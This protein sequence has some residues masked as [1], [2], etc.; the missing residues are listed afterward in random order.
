M[1]RRAFNPKG[2]ELHR[3]L[4]CKNTRGATLCR[5]ACLAFLL[6]VGLQSGSQHP[7]ALL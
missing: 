6:P 5:N 1:Y 7:P 3:F 4:L 2:M